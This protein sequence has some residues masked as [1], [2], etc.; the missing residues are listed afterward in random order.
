MPDI[1]VLKKVVSKMRGSLALSF[2]EPSYDT[3]LDV[4]YGN[5]WLLGRSPVRVKLGIEKRNGRGV[6]S[7]IWKLEPGSIDFVTALAVL[8]HIPNWPHVLKQMCRV[9]APNGRMVVTIPEPKA[10]R[11]IRLF[12]ESDAK[13]HRYI[14]PHEF[15]SELVGCGVEAAGTF[16]CGFNRF[17]VVRRV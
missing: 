16:E 14:A 11:L 7:D 3:H 9:L 12:A 13:E 5:G 4:G 8:E 15:R 1:A 17:Y 10:D 2:I 6:E